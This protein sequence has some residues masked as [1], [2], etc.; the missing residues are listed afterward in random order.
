L[1]IFT[2]EAH[3]DDV[4]PLGFTNSKRPTT[5]AERLF[6]VNEFLKS[7]PLPETTK[8]LVDN[9]DNDMAESFYAWPH[10]TLHIVDHNLVTYDERPKDAEFSLME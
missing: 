5:I 3:T 10:R 9:M 2:S 1:V 7:H 6:E 4:W 8:V